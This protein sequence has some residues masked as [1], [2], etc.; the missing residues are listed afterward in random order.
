MLEPI[1]VLIADDH[2]IV[3]AGIRLLL[4]TEPDVQVV[5]EAVTG[6]EAL[7][8]AG[9]LRPSVILMDI[10]MPG[11]TGLEATR[12]IKLR[13]P[14]IQILVLTM[15][16]SEDYFFESLKA[17]A[18]GYVLKGA[19]TG[20]LIRALRSVARGEVFLYPS[21]ARH[22]LQDYLHLVGEE[23]HSGDPSLTARERQVLRLLAEGYSNV[24]IAHRLVVSPSTV[25]SHRSN[26]MLKLNLHTRHDL[27]QY[28]RRRGLIREA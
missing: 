12:E 20:E 27:I 7:A 13:F 6:D 28:A 1:R 14:E 16:R 9:E 19:E 26:L 15:H 21:M 23:G 17:G 22:L 2:T 8:L 24:E 11:I 18:S 3:R 5:G 10:G 25:H 4:E